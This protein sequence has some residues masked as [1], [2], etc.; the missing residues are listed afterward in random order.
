MSAGAT[1]AG[2][3]SSIAISLPGL[4]PCLWDSCRRA[5]RSDMHAV[6]KLKLALELIF[7]SHS[8]S[9]PLACLAC[10]PACG[11]AAGAIKPA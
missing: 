9:R 11:T 2:S 7:L 4:H 6:V 8:A 3:P 5:L 1:M 10:T